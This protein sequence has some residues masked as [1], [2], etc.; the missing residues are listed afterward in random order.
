[1]L[2]TNLNPLSKIVRIPDKKSDGGKKENR[3]QRHDQPETEKEKKQK[4]YQSISSLV[5]DTPVRIHIN[6]VKPEELL[7]DH[8]IRKFDADS[9]RDF[10]E[11]N[12]EP[13]ILALLANGIVAED[14]MI[15][16]YPSVAM[17][18]SI[19]EHHLDIGSQKE[20]EKIAFEVVSFL[21]NG[22]ARLAIIGTLN[23]PAF[24]ADFGKST[25]GLLE[26]LKR[27]TI[28]SADL[29][30]IHVPS[31]KQMANLL[32]GT[33]D[34]MTTARKIVSHLSEGAGQYVIQK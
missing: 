12:S 14:R 34:E 13:I 23:Q 27:A 6:T 16:E 25:P 31:N 11:A 28:L 22:L 17:M 32:G 20:L 5:Y 29:G 26:K 1:M 7:Q 21:I 4:A 9:F 33:S 3:D 2:N 8:G 10:F 24:S 18:M 15:Y 30:I 19:L